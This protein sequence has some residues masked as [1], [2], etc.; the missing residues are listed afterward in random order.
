VEL[1]EKAGPVPPD[2]QDRLEGGLRQI[3]EAVRAPAEGVTI[4]SQTES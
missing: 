1:W 2:A 4:C 3:E